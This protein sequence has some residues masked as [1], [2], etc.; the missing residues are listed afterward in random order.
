[1]NGSQSLMLIV[2][3]SIAFTFILSE[4]MLP[5]W[6]FYL[7][8]LFF[9]FWVILSIPVVYLIVLALLAPRSKP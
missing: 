2:V 4:V 8:Y 1:M 9:G 5:L 6:L 3:L 7:L